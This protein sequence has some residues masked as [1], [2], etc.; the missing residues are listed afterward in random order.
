MAPAQAPSG[1]LAA[2]YAVPAADFRPRNAVFATVVSV[3]LFGTLI[4]RHGHYIWAHAAHR[5]LFASWL[6]GTVLVLVQWLLALRDRPV[7]VTPRQARQL[8]QLQVVVNI[9]VYNEA[10]GFLDRSLWA[11]VNSTRPPDVIHVVDDHSDEDYTA[12]R[13]HWE[14]WHGRTRIDWARQPANRGKKAAQAMT[15]GSYPGADI[16]V[17]V[18]SDS[19][20]ELRAIERGLAPFTDPDVWSVAGFELAW[21]ATRNW[22]TRTVSSRT[23]FFQVVACG[24][25]SVLGDVLVNRGPLAFYRA[26][27]IREVIPAYTGETFFG[28]RIKLG[29]DAALT[30]FAQ[31]RGKAVQQSDAFVFSLYPERL[32]H[33]LRQWTRWMRGSAI[34]NCWRIR[35]LPVRSYGWWF[36]LISMY[37][38]AVSLAVPAAVAA[39]WP[40]SAHVLLW[41][42]VVGVGWMYLC[43]LRIWVVRRSDETW[44]GRLVN[45]LSYPAAILWLTFVLRWIRV[46]GIVTW[47]KQGWNTRQGGAENLSAEALEGRACG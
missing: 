17:T 27:M 23:L 10:A 40:R 15:F 18:D 12:L 13:A 37:M 34:R 44:E 20:V 46:W 2:S 9:P 43:G 28:R 29:D 3:L 8:E 11:M 31:I 4:A 16:F 35:Y 1:A 14:G 19:T 45:W 42:V 6:A 5:A 25:Q 32:S 21:N 38:F 47:W 22:L 26:E 36:T 30:L 41:L 33:H 39:A 24:A 7:R